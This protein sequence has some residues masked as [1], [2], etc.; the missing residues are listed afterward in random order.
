MKIDGIDFPDLLSTALRNGELV[1][2]AGA[3][4]SMGKPACLPSFKELARRIAEGTG[5]DLRDEEPE[6]CFLGKLQHKGV[7]VH[8]RAAEILSG[9][10]LT[11][12]A[13]HENLLRLYRTVGAVRI[14]TTNFDLLFEWAAKTV[15]DC[16]PKVFLAPALPLGRDFYG[17][18]HLHGAVSD[19]GR[20]ILTDADFGR[21]YLTDGWARRFLVGLFSHFTILF[22]GYSHEDTILKYLARALPVDQA[23]QRFALTPADDDPLRWKFFGIK[24]VFYPRSSADDHSVLHEGIRKLAEIFGRGFVDWKHEITDIAK[25]PPPI[26]EEETNLIEEALKDATKTRFFTDAASSP[27]WIVWLDKRNHLDALFNEGKLSDQETALAQ[28]CAEEFTSSCT[29]ELFLLVCRHDNRLHPTFWFELGRKIGLDEQDHLDKENLARWIS[30]LLSTVPATI[31]A[32]VPDVLYWLG[33][34]CVQHGMMDSLLQVFDLMATSRL[35]LAPRLPWFED[36]PHDQRIDAELPL[37]CDHDSLNELWE[38]GLKPKLD[39]LAQPLLERLIRHLEARYLT[40]RSWKEAKTNFDPTSWDRSAIEPHEQDNYP[41][42]IDV[43]IDTVRDS[44]N[45]T[46]Q[47][48]ETN[49]AYWCDRLVASEA[50]LLRRLAVHALSARTDL[51]ADGKIDWLLTASRLHDRPAHHEIFQLAKQA[52][53]KA[54]PERRKVFVESVL[55]YRCPNEEEPDKE[56]LTARYHFDWLH[57]LHSA[58]PNCTR[59]KQALDDVQTAYPEWSPSTHPDLTYYWTEDDAEFVYPQRHLST[60]ELLARPAADWLQAPEFLGPDRPMLMFAITNVAKQ[61]FAWGAELANS[62]A[63]DNKWDAD[64]WNALIRAWSSRELDETE[65]REVLLRLE[66]AELHPKHGRSIAD[67]L[68]SLVKDGGTPYAVDLLPR[69]NEVAITLWSNLDP[70]EPVDQVGDWLTKAINHPAGVLANFWLNGLSLWR[71]QQDP[72]PGWL[73]EEYLTAL[74]VIA[75]DRALPGRLGR[76]VLASQF[77]YLLTADEHW[78]RKNLLSFFS[79]CDDDDFRAVWDGFLTVG[80]LTPTVAEAL[81]KA[82]LQAVERVQSGPGS[83]KR[84]NRFIKY[85][86]I[87]IGY[88]AK[89]P[90]GIWIPTLLNDSNEAIRRQ[91]ALEVMHCLRDLDDVRQREWWQR[92]LDRYWRNRLQGVPVALE[93]G[94]IEAML[95]WLPHLTAVFSEAVNLAIQMPSLPL[96]HGWIMHELKKGNVIESHPEEVARLLIHLGKADSPPYVWYK[97]GQELIK[98]LLQLDLS[99]HL[100]RGLKELLTKL[101]WSS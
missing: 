91:F 76:S 37:L 90:I 49:A 1:V 43:L 60:E 97:K 12:T 74:S 95:R 11:H 66:S 71:K 62:L 34:G 72:T 9:E 28:W 59:T 50:P 42:T 17:I 3:G 8:D 89:D 55:A 77:A 86:T 93:P 36:K 87:M 33:K 61:N 24:P 18:V 94:E 29:D 10:N 13:L 78:T 5:E 39:Q 81:D 7:R 58:A 83:D 19:P 44:L 64:L 57:W 56:R 25:M 2:F 68:Y 16:E 35:Q 30:L 100:K 52:Y 80:R 65:H 73:G 101:G 47:N 38:N 98:E 67:M 79:T 4:V 32:D 22:V 85:Y 6:D 92:W 75:Q 14:V 53:P 15:F 96:Q 45:W 27:E 48:Q 21:A 99:S 46:A 54:S 26:N 41:E 63:N 20:M 84:R 69:A 88:F 40:F 51:S 82:F 23:N 31:N 70:D